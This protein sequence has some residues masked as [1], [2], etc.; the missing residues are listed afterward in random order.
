M[1]IVIVLFLIW[2]SRL[3]NSGKGKVIVGRGY[4]PKQAK[5]ISSIW[6]RK[7][8]GKSCLAYLAHIRDVEVESPSIES[9]HV[10]SK[11]RE[12]F[13][14]DL[15]AISL[16]RDIDFCIDFEPGTRPIYIPPY[17]MAPTEL[18]DLKAQIQELLNNDSFVLVLPRGVLIYCLLRK[19]MAHQFSLRSGYHQL[20]IRPEDVPKMMFRICYGHY[21]FLVI[22]FGFT[23]APVAFISLMNSVFKPFHDSFVIVFID[24]I[25]VYLKSE[26][27]HV[28][29]LCFVVNV[30]GKQKL[31]AKFSKCK[32]WFTLVAFLGHV[33]SKEGP[34]VDPQTIEAEITF[35][36]TEKC[37]ESFQKLK[38]LLPTVPILALPFECKDFIAY[39]DASYSGLGAVL[40]QDKN[41]IAY[42][43]RQLMVHQRNY[44]TH[45]LELAAV[46]FTLKIWQ[47][48]L[49]GGKCKVFTDHRS[50]QH[51]FTQK[52]LNLRHIRW[53]ELLKDYY[54]TIQYY[55]GKAN[56][57]ADT[58]SRKTV[59]M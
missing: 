41:V 1:V 17:R 34:M 28:D 3:R 33:V 58:L 46:V 51:V 20:K 16:D 56:V 14:T 54:V 37:E 18:R 23:N 8:V 38:S 19:S 21:E 43:S 39:C 44:P 30:F 45:D 12:M 15:S 29:H 26:K 52:D 50:V 36:W 47:H 59:I 32:F 25:L 11:L 9:I 7:L 4:K 42:A 35:E 13:P 22:S 49:Y 27:E 31:Y 24:D 53:M 5:I 55:S 48:Y 6:V 2:V 57:V 10:V 40:M